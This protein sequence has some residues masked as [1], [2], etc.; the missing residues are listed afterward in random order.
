MPGRGLTASR[1]VDSLLRSTAGAAQG[2]GATRQ[3]QGWLFGLRRCVA[4][5]GCYRLR[6]AR[7]PGDRHPAGAVDFMP[8]RRKLLRRGVRQNDDSNSVGAPGKVRD[9]R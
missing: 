6:S 5:P 1:S 3:L 2:R 8:P 7:R 4:M 9:K